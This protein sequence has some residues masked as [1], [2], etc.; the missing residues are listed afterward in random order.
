MNMEFKIKVEIGLTPQ[1][2]ELARAFMGGCMSAKQT[3]EAEKKAS[4][5]AKAVGEPT[6]YVPETT[7]EKKAAKAG[8]ETKTAEP[9]V[10]ANPV[11]DA[12]PARNPEITEEDI[13]EAMH[14]CRLR[15]EG[16]DYKTNAD[17]EGYKKHH[18]GLTEQFKTMAKTLGYERPSILPPELRKTFVDECA[19]LIYDEESGQYRLASIPV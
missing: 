17:S 19:D 15:I 14:M 18:K 3:P 9:K 12:K 13:R 11:E 5:T 10:E 4:V 6:E 8:K 1:F 2:E 7:T 16:E